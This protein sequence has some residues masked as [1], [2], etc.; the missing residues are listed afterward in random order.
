MSNNREKVFT[1]DMHKKWINES[2]IEK[3]KDR[4]VQKSN[5]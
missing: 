4:F 2:V 3:M 5:K 1:K